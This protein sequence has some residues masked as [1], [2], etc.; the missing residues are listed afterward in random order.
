MNFADMPMQIVRALRQ[1]GYTAEHVQY[2]SGGGHK[3]GYHLDNEINVRDHASRAYAHGSALRRYV[4]ADFDVFHFWNKS[5]FFTADY[6]RLTGL[7]LPLLKA[8]GKKIVHRFSGFDLRLRRWDLERN[9]H[10]PFRHGY[11]FEADERLQ[12]AFIDLLRDY[13]DQL[14]VQDPELGQFLP[15]AR[16]IP[17][18]LDLRRWPFVGVAPTARP[19][20]IHAPSNPAV[21]GTAY[22]LKAVEALRD[23]GL[24]FDFQ[25]V[26]GMSH[27]EA[28][29]WLRRAAPTPGAPCPWMPPISRPRRCWRP[30]STIPAIRPCG[31]RWRRVAWPAT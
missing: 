10:S 22:V 7:D 27:D 16:I 28:R 29:A 24:A 13:A 17:R 12:M 20:V 31:R 30:C 9:P 5:F 2:S 19:L 4:E 26:H 25:L 11:S 14:L 1:R 18:A 3:F 23:E 21:K 8:R 6:T 15:E